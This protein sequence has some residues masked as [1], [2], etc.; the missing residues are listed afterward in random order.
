MLRAFERSERAT[1]K[2]V[3]ATS[4][5]DCAVVNNY[6]YPLVYVYNKKNEETSQYRY[7]HKFYKYVYVGT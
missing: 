6:I 5:Y 4:T 2:Y 7:L 1:T 3:K